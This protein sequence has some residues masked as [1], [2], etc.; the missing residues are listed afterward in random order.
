ME[1]VEWLE[2]IGRIADIKFRQSSM[3]NIPL[4]AKIEIVL[5][6][7]LPGFGLTRVEVEVEVL[8]FSES[9]DDY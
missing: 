9:D 8:E 1:L 3:Q 7:L 6:D 5:D 4:A 2:F